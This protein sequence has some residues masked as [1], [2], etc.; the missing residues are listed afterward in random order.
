MK[1]LHAFYFEV[2]SQLPFIHSNLFKIA[3][4][5]WIFSTFMPHFIKCARNIVWNEFSMQKAQATEIPSFMALDVHYWPY[6]FILMIVFTQHVFTF[7]FKGLPHLH[8]RRRKRKATRKIKIKKE[9]RVRT[10]N[11]HLMEKCGINDAREWIADEHKFE[12]KKSKR[13]KFNK[14]FQIQLVQGHRL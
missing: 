1:F 13:F 9:I 6:I 4:G 7:T 14:S 10:W 3:Q 11:E 12:G 5:N 2:F 8:K